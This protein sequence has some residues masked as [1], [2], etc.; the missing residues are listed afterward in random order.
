MKKELQDL[1]NSRMAELLKGQM[2]ATRMTVEAAEKL[3][4]LKD[5]RESFSHQNHPRQSS[6]RENQNTSKSN[7]TSTLITK[8]SSSSVP[9]DIV[10]MISKGMFIFLRTDHTYI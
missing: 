10:T 2:E 4:N 5:R 1:F 9:E 8:K 7:V 6:K 3:A